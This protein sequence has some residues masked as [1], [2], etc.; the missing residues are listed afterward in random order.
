MIFGGTSAA[1]PTPTQA[2][3]VAK[4]ATR[5]PAVLFRGPFKAI[6]FGMRLKCAIPRQS[7]RLWT[8][9]RTPLFRR[10]D[11][12]LRDGI[13]EWTTAIESSGDG[14][15]NRSAAILAARTAFS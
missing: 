7:A 4:H 9:F 14:G 6:I 13:G 5:K 3:R 10:Q 1:R 11:Q 8:G 12:T 15:M 2:N